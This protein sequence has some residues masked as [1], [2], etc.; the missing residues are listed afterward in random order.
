MERMEVDLQH[1]LRLQYEGQVTLLIGWFDIGIF[2][3]PAGCP[4]L[5]W[6]GQSECEPASPSSQ[7]KVLR[8]MTHTRPSKNSSGNVLHLQTI[9]LLHPFKNWETI[10]IMPPWIKSSYWL[11]TSEEIA[12]CAIYK[13]I[14]HNSLPLYIFSNIELD[15][16]NYQHWSLA[17]I[18]V[19]SS[20]KF[21]LTLSP[22]IISNPVC[23]QIYLYPF[24]MN[25]GVFIWKGIGIVKQREKMH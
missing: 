24:P 25:V 14:V 20:G 15:R 16:K 4:Q 2:L 21:W 3:F 7:C 10:Q 13:I 11:L 5:V 17:I 6:K 1:L 19:K 18:F 23:G 22:V 12:K 9:T 8:E